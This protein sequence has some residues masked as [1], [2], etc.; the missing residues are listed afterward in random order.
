MKMSMITTAPKKK[1]A[2]SLYPCTIHKPYT[3]KNQVVYQAE[4]NPIVNVPIFLQNMYMYRKKI[5]I[6][7]CNVV[8]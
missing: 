6:N 5:I 7:F 2:T 1:P 3:K 8:H 4:Q